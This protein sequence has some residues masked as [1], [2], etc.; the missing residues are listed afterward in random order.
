MQEGTGDNLTDEDV[1]DGFVDYLYYDLFDLSNAQEKDET[2]EA[3]TETHEPDDGGILLL[4]QM[5]RNQFY[6]L[7]DAVYHMMDFVFAS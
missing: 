5:V 1:K 2:L 7:E 6:R 3:Y 4:R